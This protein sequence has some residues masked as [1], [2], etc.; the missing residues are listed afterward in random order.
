M[1]LLIFHVDHFRS[2]VTERGRSPV[3]DDPGTGVVDVSNALVA[4][5][6]VERDD[7]GNPDGTAA[8]ADA[9]LDKLARQLGVEYIVLHSF[10][11][12]FC[13][14]ASPRVAVDVLQRTE[15]LLR[16]RG[17]D[18]TH[19]PFGWFNS[20]DMQAKGHPLSR[21]SRQVKPGSGVTGG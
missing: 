16:E 13:D 5:T 2:T 15:K 3:R 14:L 21:V 8:A 18:V 17:Y 1:R 11:H 20:L 4:F 9:E 12:L 10:A 19:T 6:A 7:E